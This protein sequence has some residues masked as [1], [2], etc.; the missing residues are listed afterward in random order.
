MLMNEYTYACTMYNILS[1]V[2]VITDQYL[3]ITSAHQSVYSR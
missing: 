2:C 3:S 1:M